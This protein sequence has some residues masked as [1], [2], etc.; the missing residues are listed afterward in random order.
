VG[1]EG[2]RSRFET[3]VRQRSEAEECAVVGGCLLCVAD[4]PGGVSWRYLR[5]HWRGLPVDVVIATVG[6]VVCSGCGDNTV[7]IV[8]FAIRSEDGGGLWRG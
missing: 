3:A 2:T 6:V 1:G 7:E 5:D 8:G 4:P